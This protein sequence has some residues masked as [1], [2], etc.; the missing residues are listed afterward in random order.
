MNL[1]NR[2]TF[3]FIFSVILVALFAVA[4]AMAQTIE[5]T[6]STDRNDDNTANDPGWSVTIGGLAA[7]DTVTVTYLDPD[8]TAA[9]ATG[10]QAGFDGVAADATSDTGSILA[11][12][13]DV[14]AVQVEAGPSGTT[15]TYQRVTFPAG[16]PGATLAS[17]TLTRLPKLMELA[18]SE[19]YV[20]FGGTVTLTFDFAD[21]V[22]DTNGA[23]VA[24]LHISD[25]S[26]AAAT[27]WVVDS[28]SGTNQ[29]TIRSTHDR[30]DTSVGTTVDLSAVYA[31]PTDPATDGQ[32]TLT[33][34][35]MAPTVTA[36]SVSVAAPSG[37]PTPPDGVW[38]SV[39][40]LTF[41]VSDDGTGSGLP[42]ENP[43]RIDTDETKLDVGVVGLAPASD[44]VGT[45]YLVRITPKVGRA[46][47]AGEEV[48][49]TIVPIDKS[50]NEGSMATTVK[51]AESTPPDALYTSAAPASGDVMQGDEITVTFA[52]DPGAVTATG[53][54]ISGTGAT[55]TLTVDAA[56]AVG[57]LEIVLTWGESGRQVLNYT[58]VIP[59]VAF[60]SAAP[61]SGATVEQGDTITL[62][63]ASDPGTV[64]ATGAAISGTGETRT[65]TVA[66]DQAAGA[67]SIA[68]SW[69]N[70]GS[71]ALSYTVSVFVSANPTSPSNIMMVEI[72]AES[73]VVLVRSMSTTEGA[74]QFPDVPPVNGT[75][76]DV[77]AWS[78]MP[79]LWDLFQRTAQNR[80][81]AIVLRKS[82]DA[83]D[84]DMKNDDDEYIGMYATPAVGSVGISEIM[85]ARDLGQ[86]TAAQ[87]A[88]GQWIE[89]QNLND[90]P[91]KVLIYAQKGSEG[92]VSGGL[93]VDTAAGDSLLG[94]PGGMV[95]DAVQNI[96]N[97]G[98]QTNDGWDIKGQDGNSVE[99]VSFASMHRILPDKQPAYTL[100]QNYTKRKGTNGGHWA[101]SGGAYLRSQ[102]THT[103]GGV[104]NVPILFDY[105]G[106]PGDVNNRTGIDFHTKAGKTNLS[107]G[108]ELIFNEIANRSDA[109]KDYEWIEILNRT[110]SV[111]SLRSYIITM[112]TK[113]GTNDNDQDQETVLYHFAHD[114]NADVPANGVLLLVASD[115]AKDDEHPL[116]VGYNVDENEEDQVPGFK[117]DHV[118][119]YKV[120]NFGSN[121]LPNGNFVLV[122]RRPDTVEGH[123]DGGRGRA[124][125]GR[126][127]FDKIVDM[128]GYANLKA[129]NYPNPVSNTNLWPLDDFPAPGYTN[130]NLVENT[131]HSRAVVRDNKD[132]DRLGTG[133]TDNDN[134]KSAYRDAGFT[135]I[136]YRRDVPRDGRY[137][138]TPGYHG[139]EKGLATDLTDDVVISELMLS[140]G[141]STNRQLPQWIEITNNS[142]TKTVN[143]SADS[144]WRLVIE[145]PVDAIRTLNFKDK[146]QVKY[147]YPKQTILIVAGSPTRNAQAGSDR[148]SNDIIFKSDRVFNV[149]R[150]YG[151]G[152]TEI[153]D[154]PEDLRAPL[155]KSDRYRFLNQKHFNIRLIDGKGT[156]ADEVGNLDGNPRTNDTADWDYPSGL[157]KDGDRTS[158][159]R[160]FDEGLKARQAVGSDAVD[161]LPLDA[162][163]SGAVEEGK[164]DLNDYDSVIPAE[165]AW[166]HAAALN[167]D[168]I[169]VRHTW[170]GS[171]DDYGTPGA[172]K[173]QVLPVQLSFFRPTL[174]D[175][176][177]VIRWTTESELDNAGFNIYRSEDRNGEFTKVNEQLIQGKGTTAERSTYNWVD[178]SAKPGAVYYYQIE[179]VSF[180][181]ER[182]PLTTTKL[183]GLIS[184]KNK[185]TT[186]WSE[187]KSQN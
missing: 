90:K 182:N 139:S 185:L 105:R 110:D 14:I 69:A 152:F 160:V 38:D 187:L 72:P 37:F 146:G 142:G 166:I 29:V 183:K 98:N 12:I 34:D 186:T 60:T 17:T 109:D 147:I 128:A 2:L 56:Q 104:T 54:A 161:V 81:G 127:D 103:S 113:K 5:A 15:T 123:D 176:Q 117:G 24:D 85:W 7:S 112:L 111:K 129:T 33:Y 25:V 163:R 135:G 122:L 73:Y 133:A 16:G 27:D 141:S 170:Y 102:T 140:T 6:W 108:A 80:G 171:E 99:G 66:D 31:Q 39:F 86:G 130:N 144:G 184:A 138:G 154:D 116:S 1:S 77:Q 40:I 52:S 45:E 151:T 21:A 30:T 180:A 78:D 43:V 84:N 20:S 155:T 97:D 49:I 76:V 68:L 64:T 9:A 91:V 92:L 70:G 131:V 44:V 172:L 46:T 121:G 124:E 169:Y 126:A 53:A 8:G 36:D 47:T 55:R 71:Q 136:G 28:V 100:A 10:T 35:N 165:Y 167:F 179:D 32:A 168:S 65:L 26:I 4:P 164:L 106:T 3:S 156:V 178:T 101:K 23:P 59:A 153:Q 88:A 94:N 120:V 125:T 119:R 173:G 95:I 42:D 143:L 83:A 150:E 107:D 149:L 181:G 157:T 93:L 13:G 57:A 67:L 174:E 63:F 74:L 11:G 114:T 148:L 58:V 75:A 51:L 158:F 137:G 175:G 41:S 118:P 18:K 96:R 145:T 115:P 134:N 48:V 87:Q 132:G 162:V 22:A 89:L 82:A 19:Y 159:I 50:G 61:A 62:T 79:D 177:V